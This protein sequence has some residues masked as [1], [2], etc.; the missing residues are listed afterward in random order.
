MKCPTEVYQPSACVYQGLQDIDYPL[1]DKVIV[2]TRC[3]L[4]SLGRKKKSASAPF[5]PARRV[6]LKES[7]RRYLAC[8]FYGFK[9]MA[10][11]VGFEPTIR[12][13]VCSLSRRVLSTTQ[14]PL[15]GGQPS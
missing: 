7:A 4:I 8:E 5:L 13:P 9:A 1:Y 12:F 11:R 2:V 15:R 3:G 6:A 14:S 10:E